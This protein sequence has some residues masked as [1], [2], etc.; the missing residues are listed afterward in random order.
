MVWQAFNTSDPL[1]TLGDIYRF[2]PPRKKIIEQSLS[3]P[4]GEEAK[5]RKQWKDICSQNQHQGVKWLRQQENI[6]ALYA[7]LYRNDRNWLLDNTPQPVKVT[8][9]NT[10]VDWEKRDRELLASLEVLDSKKSREYFRFRKSKTWFIRHS[11]AQAILGKHLDKLPLCKSFID[12]H[13]ETVEEFHQRKILAAVRELTAEG[14]ALPT[15]V[16]IRRAGIREQFV[17]DNLIKLIQDLKEPKT[18]IV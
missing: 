1:S 11:E 18:W 13:L 10:K 17:T 7:W 12:S 9:A 16:I 4:T 5:K 14:S 8:V 3:K 6:G 2:R 15:W